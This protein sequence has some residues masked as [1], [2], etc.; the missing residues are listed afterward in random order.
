MTYHSAVSTARLSSNTILGRGFNSSVTQSFW[1]AMEV[2]ERVDESKMLQTMKQLEKVLVA[3]DRLKNMIQFYVVTEATSV[4]TQIQT[5]SDAI[6]RMLAKTI[7][8]NFALHKELHDLYMQYVDQIVNDV[9]STLQTADLLCAQVTTS[10]IADR[11]SNNSKAIRSLIRQLGS[12]M[13]KLV[14]FTDNLNAT[15]AYNNQFFPKRLLTSPTC[16]EAKKSLNS[17]VVERRAWLEGFPSPSEFASDTDLLKM[18]VLRSLLSR[19]MNCLQGYKHELDDFSQWL[20]S[21]QPPRFDSTSSS[22]LSVSQS[23]ADNRKLREIQ[24]GFINGSLTKKDLAHQYLTINHKVIELHINRLV[25]NVK[26]SVITKLNTYVET[27]EKWLKS[28]HGRLFETYVVLQEYMGSTDKGIERYAR[29]QLIW[30]QP[31]VNFQSPQVST[32][33]CLQDSNV[34]GR[35]PNTGAISTGWPG[36]QI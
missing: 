7:K 22:T 26:Q 25:S 11:P 1:D 21:V 34:N 27:F 32:S 4:S 15:T 16:H 5:F 28:F 30:R 20:R 8:S 17:T 6:S 29:Q 33:A 36:K 31:V 18:S 13:D 9:I 35:Y 10:F 14:S 23:D 2:A 12:V 24:Q 19:T 3:H